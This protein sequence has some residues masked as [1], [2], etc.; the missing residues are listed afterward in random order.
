MKL[1]DSIKEGISRPETISFSCKTYAMKLVV[2]VI[3]GL[4]D[5]CSTPGIFSLRHGAQTG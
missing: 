3:Y 4:D 2:I 1:R 5:R